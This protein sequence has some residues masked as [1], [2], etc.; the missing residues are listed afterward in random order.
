VVISA[1]VKMDRSRL[2]ALFG[3]PI[4]RGGQP[5][6]EIFLVR[7]GIEVTA[8]FTVADG[9]LCKLEIPSG[10]ADRQRVREILEQAVPV[11]ERGKKWNEM[12]LYTGISGFT[13]IYYERVVVSEQLFTSEAINQNPGAAVVFKRESCGWAAG[14]VFDRPPQAASRP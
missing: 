7:P 3:P 14:D 10:V 13:N 4:K 5:G 2:R 12:M 1:Q 9:M 8:T 6:T 11:A